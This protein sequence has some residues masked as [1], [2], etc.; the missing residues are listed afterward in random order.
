MIIRHK[1]MRRLFILGGALTALLGLF[2]CLYVAAVYRNNRNNKKLRAQAM[3]AFDTGDY[4]KAVELLGNYRERITPPDPQVEFR[5]GM[6]RVHVELP[7]DKHLTEA[8]HVFE[9]YLENVNPNDVKAKQELI[10][11]YVNRGYNTEA[12]RL[13]DALLAAD[14][15]DVEAQRSEVFALNGQHKFE[16]ALAA[17]TKLNALQP[18]D[19]DGQMLTLALM[20]QLHQPVE[21]VIDHAQKLMREH[22]GD[23]RFE[24]LLA[25]AYSQEHLPEESKVWLSTAAGRKAPD[26]SFA[27]ELVAQLDRAELF[28]QASAFLTRADATLNDVTLHRLLAQRL[29]QDGKVNEMVAALKDQQANQP[30]SDGALLGYRALALA[31]LKQRPPAQ[32]IAKALASR[33]DA[34]SAAW[35]MGLQA[36]LADVPLAAPELAGRLQKAATRDPA[37]C[38]L[39]MMLADAYLRMDESELAIEQ[40][41]MAYALAPSWA[42]PFLVTAEAQSRTGRHADAMASAWAA[43]K[44]G[45]DRYDTSVMYART[46]FAW[47]QEAGISADWNRLLSALSQIQQNFHDP[48]TLP[49]YVTVLARTGNRDRAIEVIRSSL[50][51]TPALP[52]ATL[53]QLAEVSDA[54]KLGVGDEVRTFTAST[55]G[56]TPELALSQARALLIAGKRQE[57]AKGLAAAAHGHETELPWREAIAAFNEASGQAD[58]LADWKSLGEQYPKDLRLQQDILRSATRTRDRE[59]W[60]RT[61]NRVKALTGEQ[62]VLWR[63][64]R[65]RW[66]LGGELTERD[67]A[68]AVNLLT[69]VTG[70]SPGLSEPHRLL[71]MAME[72]LNNL[73]GAITELTAAADARPGDAAITQELVRLLVATHRNSDAIAYLDKLAAGRDLAP[74]M[75]LWVAQA[76]QELGA[77]DKAMGLLN[78]TGASAD[79]P[80]AIDRQ[81]LLASIAARDGRVDEAA[82][83]YKKLL[84]Q[85]IDDVSFWLGGADFFASRDDLQTADLFMKKV[86]ALVRGPGELEL[87]RGRFAERWLGNEQALREYRSAVSS[88]PASGAAWIAL[89]QLQLRTHQFA[90]A[91]ATAAAALQTLHVEPTLSAIASAASSLAKLGAVNELSPLIDGLSQDPRNAVCNEMLSDLCSAGAGQIQSPDLARKLANLAEAHP[92]NFAAAAQACR[93]CTLAGLNDLALEVAHRCADANPKSAEC[94][95]LL[96]GIYLMQGDWPHAEQS[97][98]LWRQYAPDQARSAAVVLAEIDLQQT[99]PDPAA[100]IEALK[101]FA[102]SASHP[103]T[104]ARITELYTRALVLAGRADEAADLLRP[105][106]PDSPRWRGVWLDL[107]ARQKDASAAEGWIEQVSPI[108]PTSNRDEQTALAAAW[109]EVGARFHATAPLQK[110]RDI[111]DPLLKGPEDA[112]HAWVIAA[113]TAQEAGDYDSAE[114][115]YR[116][117]L[118]Y[119]PRSPDARNNL[120]YLLWLRGRPADVAEGLRLAQSAVDARPQDASF[121]DT[122]A[123]L[124]ARA[125]D[126]A[127]AVNTFKTALSKNPSSLEALIGQADLLSRNAATKEQAKDLLPQIQTLLDAGANL[128]PVLQ[129]EYQ[130]TKDALASTF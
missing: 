38:V 22:P 115:A 101:P 59:F 125:G 46:Y 63:V 25:F 34:V 91:R 92:E 90:D 114:T 39:H 85:P 21:Q 107:A 104:D 54:Q 109:Y 97:A 122:L 13:A 2:L 121:Y 31:E 58:A 129:K 26:P 20:T 19:V 48:Q 16:Q 87:L 10:Q 56:M 12:L 23:P 69:Q 68:E 70:A 27:R 1:T 45:P 24:L 4:A 106:L 89:A 33:P 55:E 74:A 111:L 93:C 49:M 128:P 47:A 123:R 17:A 71:A 52:T 94:Q 15:R 124:Q 105:L 72:R 130:T 98:M 60:A 32:E 53:T 50:R 43:V 75:R 119:D 41:R 66:L 40:C 86:A 116:R 127:G 5:Y 78:D 81:R 113:L 100:A 67:K 126:V 3:V 9:N 36:A 64:E 108:V 35:G 11:L 77:G 73:P 99:K 14:P 112:P 57:A 84:D 44:R 30:T 8:I 7:G 88:A 79:G 103:A 95:R 62:G 28:S 61:I 18:F 51:A 76:Y 29:W 110:A 118:Q 120:A 37:N 96:A 117:V 83:L 6:A 102:G 65:A 42:A 80:G 82:A